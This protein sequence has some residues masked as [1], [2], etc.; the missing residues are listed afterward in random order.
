VWA[1]IPLPVWHGRIDPAEKLNV[2]VQEVQSLYQVH[3]YGKPPHLYG[4]YGVCVD[5]LQLWLIESSKTRNYTD[6]MFWRI[7]DP[8]NCLSW[9]ICAHFVSVPEHKI[10]QHRPTQRIQYSVFNTPWKIK[11]RVCKT[12]RWNTKAIACNLLKVQLHFLLHKYPLIESCCI[13][14]H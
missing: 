5:S 9:R 10:R 2:V 3:A 4:F 12:S 14:T 13:N 11:R 8:Y 6:C 7:S 1:R